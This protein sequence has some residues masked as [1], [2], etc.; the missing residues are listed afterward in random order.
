MTISSTATATPL[1]IPGFLHG[2]QRG[3]VPAGIMSK[4][5]QRAPDPSILDN[6]DVLIFAATISNDSLDTFATRMA[7]S[8]LRNYARD[9]ERGVPLMVGHQ[10]LGLPI[11]QSVSGSYSG[12]TVH[13]GARVDGTI[14]IVGG[15][16]IDG[17]DLDS[18]I[19]AVRSGT[20]TD[21]SIG[22]TPGRFECSICGSDPFDWLA[23]RC[24]HVPA[25]EY[26]SKGGKDEMAFAWVIDASLREVS[27]VYRGATPGAAVTGVLPLASEKAGRLASAGRLSAHSM[28]LIERRFGRPLPALTRSMAGAHA[29]QAPAPTVIGTVP[30]APVGLP[31]HLDAYAVRGFWR[32]G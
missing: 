17:H 30:V 9:L 2:P 16:V 3:D 32:R 21:V 19:A 18:V 22:F 20:V 12:A 25:L 26:E 31:S 15:S 13:Q 24:Q 6:R 10:L 28:D 8:S 23:T 7:E 27:L 4:I 14:Y 1:R 11:G 29:N 5:R